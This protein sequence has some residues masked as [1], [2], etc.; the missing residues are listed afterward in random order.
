[1][2]VV[3]PVPLDRI[4]AVGG[5]LDGADPNHRGSADAR[6]VDGDERI[7]VDERVCGNIGGLRLRAARRHRD[8]HSQ[9]NCISLHSTLRWVQVSGTLTPLYTEVSAKSSNVG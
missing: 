2:E 3:C 1:V 9:D 4:D 6:L 7:I 5:A 8:E